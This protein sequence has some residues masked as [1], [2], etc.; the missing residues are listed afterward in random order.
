MG[1]DVHKSNFVNNLTENSQKQV[2]MNI[3]LIAQMEILKHESKGKT[4]QE[5]DIFNIQQLH[6]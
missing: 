5:K 1:K 4:Q 3:Y 6:M 2:K